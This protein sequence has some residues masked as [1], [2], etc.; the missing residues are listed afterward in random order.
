MA[1]VMSVL[2]LAAL[3]S[4]VGTTSTTRYSD[5]SSIC[6]RTGIIG[7]FAGCR[8]S[9]TLF[10]KRAMGGLPTQGLLASHN[11]NQLGHIYASGPSEPEH[12]HTGQFPSGDSSN[13]MLELSSGGALG[14]GGTDSRA[15]FVPIN[16]YEML[17][18]WLLD[19]YTGKI[20]RSN[21]D[22][23]SKFLKDGDHF[24]LIKRFASTMSTSSAE[25]PSKPLGLGRP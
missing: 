3:V 4:L 21:K 25:E 1:C 16:G 15:S 20:L 14:D 11:E 9:L 12:H 24:R 8:C 10:S 6:H 5:C 22:S 19:D 13:S 18:S 23:L 7:R 17:P 2:A